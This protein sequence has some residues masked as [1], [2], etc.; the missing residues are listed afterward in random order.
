MRIRNR[1]AL[2]TALMA[3]VLIMAVWTVSGW[4]EEGEATKY[5]LT[6]TDGWGLLDHLSQVLVH[7]VAEGETSESPVATNDSPSNPVTF[8]LLPGTYTITLIADVSGIGR[9]SWTSD[10]ITLAGDKT[11]TLPAPSDG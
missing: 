1:R 7:A 5:T 6:I 4:A 3:A 9:L 8:Q 10:P 11:L 2:A